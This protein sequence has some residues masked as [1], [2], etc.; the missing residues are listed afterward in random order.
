MGKGSTPLFLMGTTGL[1]LNT[2]T[3][4]HIRRTT[5]EILFSPLQ[6][7]FIQTRVRVEGLIVVGSFHS[8]LKGG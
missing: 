2:N 8:S 5:L 6:L 1:P 3:A 7:L 4:S